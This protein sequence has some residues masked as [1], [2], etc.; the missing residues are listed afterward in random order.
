MGTIIRPIDQVL[1]VLYGRLAKVVFVLSSPLTY[2]PPNVK[3][4]LELA[5][6]FV[7][8]RFCDYDVGIEDKDKL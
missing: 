3:H 2:R 8:I 7:L 6:M 5:K 1:Q 4:R